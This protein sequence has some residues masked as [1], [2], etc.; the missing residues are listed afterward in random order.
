VSTPEANKAAKASLDR[1]CRD[2]KEGKV[3]ALVTAPINKEALNEGQR[4]DVPC[5]KGNDELAA[6][7]Y[8]LH[9]NEQAKRNAIKLPVIRPTAW[10]NK[11]LTLK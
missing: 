10:N 7:A 2:L 6:V 4:D 5:T 3:H 8:A 9:L 1:A 11:Y